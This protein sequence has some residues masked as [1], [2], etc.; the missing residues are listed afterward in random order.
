MEFTKIINFCLVCTIMLLSGLSYTLLTPMFPSEGLARQVS[1]SQTGLVMGSAF[2]TSLLSTPCSSKLVSMYGAKSVFVFAAFIAGISNILFGF[3]SYTESPVLFFWV[4]LILRM[5][6]AVGESLVSSTAFTLG[7]SQ[8]SEM[9]QGK[10]ISILESCFGA[11]MAA[12]PSLGGLFY[13]YWGFSMPFWTLGGLTVLLTVFSGMVVPTSKDSASTETMKCSTFSSWKELVC[14]PHMISS[15][16]LFLICGNS[17]TLYSASLEPYLM[18]KFGLNP[19]E[20]G[21]VFMGFPIAYTIMNPIVGVLLDSG[22]SPLKTMLMGNIVIAMAMLM[23]GIQGPLHG[24]EHFVSVPQIIVLIT[25][26]GLGTACVSMGLFAHMLFWTSELPKTEHTKTVVSSI[27][28]MCWELSGLACTTFGSYS[29]DLVG[30]EWSCFVEGI[31]LFL[32]VC[33]MFGNLISS[34]SEREKLLK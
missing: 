31:V 5:I 27:W 28:L 16:A 30:F 2:I 3:L 4:S 17:N 9:H 32:P 1:V 21:L 12:G 11:G 18:Q 26:Q 6:C 15:I 25:V 10:S 19:G 29:Y 20:V 7:S 23:L 13:N 14:C 24:L 22:I 33:W 34:S 8:F